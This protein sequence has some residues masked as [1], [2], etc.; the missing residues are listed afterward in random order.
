M[1]SKALRK[2][3]PRTAIGGWK[4]PAGRD[5]LAVLARNEQGRIPELVTL[6]H[7]RMRADVFG[8]YRGGAAIM[9]ADLTTLPVTGLHVQLG[10]DAHLMNFGG[11]ATPE[12]R[13]VFDVNDFDETLV[14]PWE[15]DIARLCA[16][17]PL[18]VQY[19]NFPK[20]AGSAAAYAAANSYRRKMRALAGLSPLKI[21][22]SRVDVK[23]LLA[24]E[25]TLPTSTAN[26]KPSAI[27]ETLARKA[28]LQYGHTLPPYVRQLLD[29]YELVDVIDHPV[30]V[31]SLGLVA[32]IATF[33]SREG[34]YSLVLQVKEAVASVLEEHLGASPFHNHAE[35]VVAGAHSM[36]AASDPF[37]GWMSSEG[38]DYYVRQ[39]RDQKASLDIEHIT[40]MQLIDFAARCGAVLARAHARTGHPQAIATYLGSRD[41]FERA[42]VRF[43]HRYARV[44]R[45]DYEAFRKGT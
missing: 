8:F 24:S 36:Q 17:L 14:G 32:A 37:L 4:P 31:G 7:E 23:G 25:L 19:R 27:V 40:A 38:R 39:F 11:Y 6:R 18:A 35:R 21:W 45:S 13:L 28:F 41:V 20:R 2:R 44:V 3:V 10:G 42:M 34:N 33:K 1:P 16:S 12:R 29:R 26:V 15:W 43:A 22:Y 30:G 5:P 9:A